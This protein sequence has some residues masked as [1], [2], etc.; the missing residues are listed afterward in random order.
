MLTASR[1]SPERADGKSD[2]AHIPAG[3][4]LRCDSFIIAK[5]RVVSRISLSARRL[6]QLSSA[7]ARGKMSP[8]VD[9]K[10]HIV[11]GSDGLMMIFYYITIF[12][13]SF[14]FEWDKVM[15]FSGGGAN[16]RPKMW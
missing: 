4:R 12:Y 15:F 3:R 10:R 2:H 9:D 13:Y 16:N 7:P 5:C 6:C 1:G 11:T 14:G 8:C